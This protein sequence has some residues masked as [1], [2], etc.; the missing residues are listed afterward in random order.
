MKLTSHRPTPDRS[1]CPN[2]DNAS[3][4][5]D[6]CNWKFNL[7]SHYRT[8]L[9]IIHQIIIPK[10]PRTR[11]DPSISPDVDDPDF[12]CKSCQT[13]YKNRDKYRQH[14]RY[15][16][17]ME[18]LPLRK[19]PIYDLNTSPDD[20]LMINNKSCTICKVKYRNKYRYQAHM[21]NHHKA[22]RNT[23][24]IRGRKVAHPNISPDPNDPNWFCLSC[25]R[26]YSSRCSY[27][28]HIRSM[29]PHVNID[30][31]GKK[32]VNSI[33]VEMDAGNPKNKRCTIC[34]REYINRYTYRKHMLTIHK[35]GKREAVSRSR[36][37][38]RVNPNIIPIWDDPNSYCR[39]CNQTFSTKWSY[40]KH[41]KTQH[42]KVLQE[43]VRLS[44]SNPTQ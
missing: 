28:R 42:S 19:K 38:G 6:S 30:N 22:G 37:K 40:R 3:N 10:Q 41:I 34:D 5:C 27:E 39:S 26:R 7:R 18:L 43:S 24:I 16:H 13:K 11:P 14:L 8:H 32:L 20:T 25:Q 17:R 9:L 4:Y 1:I 12:Q 31:T 15:V 21:K 36:D 35:D 23:P 33:M 2:P 29:H 44:S